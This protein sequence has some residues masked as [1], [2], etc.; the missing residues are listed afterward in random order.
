MSNYWSCHE[1]LWKTVRL[2]SILDKILKQRLV[3]AYEDQLHYIDPSTM[4]P[5][6]KEDLIKIN[7]QL[8]KNHTKPI[9]ETIHHWRISKVMNITDNI[10]DL[11]E[12]LSDHYYSGGKTQ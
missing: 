1:K 12:R 7:N 9:K 10:F 11:Y 6:L 8:T 4:P 5:H 2:L 3:A